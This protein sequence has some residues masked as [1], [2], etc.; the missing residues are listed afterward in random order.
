MVK[1]APQAVM[2]FVVLQPSKMNAVYVVVIIPVAVGQIS[3][4]QLKKLT[5]LL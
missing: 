4:Q 1:M 2:K 5:R 3:Q